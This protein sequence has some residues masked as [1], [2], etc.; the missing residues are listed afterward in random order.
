MRLVDCHCH[1]ESD[2]FKD[3]LDGIIEGARRAGIVKLLTSSI[4]PDEWP[5]S[6]AISNRYKEVEFALGV[7]PWYCRPEDLERIGELANAAAE[8]AVAIGEIGLDKKSPHVGLDLQKS[9][10]EA[11]LK[12]A[13]EIDLP[14]IIHC[15]GAF[16]ELLHYFKR[17]GLPRQ[18]GII[19]S[20]SGSVEIAAEYARYG[21]SFS[22]GGAITFRNSKRKAAVLKHVYPERIVLETDS[23]DIPP[24]EAREMPNVPA[25]ILYAL[26][27]AAEILDASEEQIAETTTLNAAR[28]F[29]LAI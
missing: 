24:V 8:G 6:R 13:R 12:I 28:I 5:L 9:L 15:R 10:F 7:H 20:F 11:Q 19:H 4:T 21:A 17:I 1:L 18:G 22:F 26:R 25:N 29:N 23:P 3:K 2:F 27:A 16:D 14:V